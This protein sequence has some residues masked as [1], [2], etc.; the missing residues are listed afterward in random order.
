MAKQRQSSDADRS[1]AL[2]VS[3]NCL[4]SKLRLINRAVGA[5]YDESLRPLGLKV[6]QVNVLVAISLLGEI[7]PTELGRALAIDKSTLSRNVERLEA[8]GWIEPVQ[9]DDARAH[10]LRVTPSGRDVLRKAYSPWQQAQRR[11]RELL[12][13]RSGTIHEI[14]EELRAR[15]LGSG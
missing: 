15:S 11:V 3:S 4:A 8:H 9:D 7:R 1:L 13:E 12:G 14:A 10:R 2:D 6:S 5:I